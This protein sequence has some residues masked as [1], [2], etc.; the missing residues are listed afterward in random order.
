MV[1]AGTR[2]GQTDIASYELAS[3]STTWLT[4]TPGGSEYSPQQIPGK[5]NITAI[6]L[7][8]T[9]LQRLYEYFDGRSRVLLPELKVGYQ[10]WVNHDLLVCTVLKEDRM[11][12]VVA[13]PGFQ[14]ASTYQRNVGRSLLRIPK[15]DRISYASWEDG[16]R[17][18]KSMDPLSGATDPIVQLPDGVQDICWLP[19]GS[20]ICGSDNKLL[21][22]APSQSTDWEV[23]HEFEADFGRISRLAVHPKGKQLA[24]VVQKSN[25]P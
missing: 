23:W 5:K 16:H 6:R 15:S 4:H 25:T 1:Y 8:T 13:R 2:S 14:T 20:L 9:G 3:G 12:L 17:W 21:R 22:Y 24:L 10:V 7:D 18:V 11:D 19:D